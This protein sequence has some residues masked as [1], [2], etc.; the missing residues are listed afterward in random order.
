MADVAEEDKMNVYCIFPQHPHLC[1]LHIEK[2]LV[3]CFKYTSLTSALIDKKSNAMFANTQM[4]LSDLQFTEI[5]ITL[6]FTGEEQIVE[7]TN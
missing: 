3:N 4:F 7:G 2:N 5:Q 6:C 1:A